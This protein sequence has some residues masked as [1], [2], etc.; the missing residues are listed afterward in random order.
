MT[1]PVV[2]RPIWLWPM[3]A[4]HS[5]PS[6]P[7]A[8]PIGRADALSPT[9]MLYSVK[10]PPEKLR[11]PL[12]LG[13]RPP[14]PVG[15][16]RPILP[17]LYSVNHSALSGPVTM[18]WGSLL[19]VGIAYSVT[20]WAVIDGGAGDTVASKIASSTSSGARARRQRPPRVGIPAH[21]CRH[22]RAPARAVVLPRGRPSVASGTCI[23]QGRWRRHARVMSNEL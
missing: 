2:M 12:A 15:S 23:V 10:L 22:I 20:V 7:T 11:L 8:I 6:E 21:S 3:S 16:K 9:G 4:N 1:P 14:P 13:E 17:A 5:A 18:A 19:A